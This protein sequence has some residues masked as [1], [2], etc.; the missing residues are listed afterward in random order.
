MKNSYLHRKFAL[1]PLVWSL[2]IAFMS[3]SVLAQ[4]VALERELEPTV[5]TDTRSPLDPNLPA[6]TFSITREE[7]KNQNVVNVQDGLNYAPN[8]PVRKL[9]MADRNG[10]IG[11][12]NSGVGQPYRTL[13]YVDGMLITNLLGSHEVAR[14]NTV[15]PDEVGRYDVLYG[16]FSA[17]YPGNS[18]GTTVAITTRTPQKLEFTGRVLGY[19]ATQSNFGINQSFTGHTESVYLGNRWGNFS[20]SIS[21]ENTLAR[22]HGTG[23]AYLTTPKN[24][25]A[26]ATPVTG[27]VPD[28]DTFGNPRLIAGTSGMEN[29]N[30]RMA[31]IRLNY[32]FTPEF[33][34]DLT[35]VRVNNS[36]QSNS[37]TLLRDAAGL[38]VWGGVVSV[39]G[40]K[41]DVGDM[42]PREGEE[43]H[44]QI[45]LRLRSRKKQGWNYS[46]QA[47]DFRMLKQRDWRSNQHFG[48]NGGAGPGTE[49]VSDGTGWRTFEVQST[50][51]PSQEIGHALSFG[52]HHNDYKIKSTTYNL[53]EWRNSGSRI[54]VNAS[55]SGK[56]R[57]QA[58]YAQDSWRFKPGWTLTA[59]LRAE[60][61]D[62]FDGTQYTKTGSR[63]INYPSRTYDALSPKLSL[64]HEINDQWLI[65][66]SYGRGVRFPT[67]VEL[68][69]SVVTG[70]TLVTANPGL[71]PEKSDA[72]EISFIRETGDSNLRISLFEDDIKDA[73]WRQTSVVPGGGTATIYT[74]V[75]RVRTRGVEVAY[76][77]KDVL[78]PGVDLTGSAS[79]QPSRILKNP[80]TPESVGQ[81]WQALPKVR[82]S[83]LTS[84]RRGP[85][86]TSLGI[87]HEG[88]RSRSLTNKETY[89]ETYGGANAYTVADARFSWD[90]N[91]WGSLAIGVN[92]LTNTKYYET[93]PYAGRTAFVELK[94]NY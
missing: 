67:A 56:T 66:A 9:K 75:D 19:R 53:S 57:V 15:S 92:N 85:W 88:K 5:V 87:R 60:R 1:R 89:L 48:N 63:S 46:V 20:G 26:A 11:T 49:A 7:T 47:S 78:F 77:K 2:A 81:P 27:A 62:A 36:T 64:A 94:A 54:D 42:K 6:S 35:Y 83:L 84:Y 4:G 73:I 22:T 61:Y 93:H 32:D 30:P 91:K 86:Q 45:G 10:G 14:W 55:N 68:F 58:L 41:Y 3:G 37:E 80:L 90:F 18:I 74:N 21:M 76:T 59:G 12:R 43:D 52:Y 71:N 44:Q 28:R 13:T 38:P 24:P 29:S 25:G 16:P 31:K 33:S 51:T 17:I 82:A 65:R 23:Y 79:L 50:Y 69:E 8:M 34:G 39:G 72:K 70:N 40:I